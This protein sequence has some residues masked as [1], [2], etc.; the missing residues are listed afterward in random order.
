MTNFWYAAALNI[1]SAPVVSVE[2]TVISVFLCH[3]YVSL[4]Y[5]AP[6]FSTTLDS[7]GALLTL[8]LR[9][10]TDIS[11]FMRVMKYTVAAPLLLYPFRSLFFFVT[12]IQ[13]LFVC[14]GFCCFCLSIVIIFQHLEQGRAHERTCGLLVGKRIVY[15]DTAVLEL[16]GIVLN[17]FF[18]LLLRWKL[19]LFT[20]CI[21]HPFSP[22][23]LFFILFYEI[24]S[25]IY[26]T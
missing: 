6:S 9:T 23:A 16:W 10:W 20:C 4:P 14:W 8:I 12:V 25:Q 7:N 19:L 5:I 11:L 18:S 15:L 21:P 26:S 3:R 22:I 1:I 2:I 24:F 17:Y 13:C